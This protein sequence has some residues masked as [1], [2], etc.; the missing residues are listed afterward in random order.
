MG[1]PGR[2]AGRVGGG[3]AIGRGL[4]GPFGS[5]SGR[6]AGTGAGGAMNCSVGLGALSSTSG[7]LSNA[8]VFP[9][10]TSNSTTPL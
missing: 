10:K 4:E 8:P 3:G 1:T 2:G 5:S 6:G 7:G 9:L